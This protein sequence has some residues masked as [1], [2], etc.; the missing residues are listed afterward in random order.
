M[1]E[2]SLNVPCKAYCTQQGGQARC[3]HNP[4]GAEE[5]DENEEE[6]LAKIGKVKF[7]PGPDYTPRH[8]DVF[9]VSLSTTHEDVLG[10][11][12]YSFTHS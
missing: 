1:K 3:G 12:K 11:W 8:E 2:L 4:G 5:T 6:H 9:L 10:Q 7:V